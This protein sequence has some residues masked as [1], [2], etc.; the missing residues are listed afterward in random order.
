VALLAVVEE[1]VVVLLATVAFPVLL[2]TTVTL[3]TTTVELAELLLSMVEFTVLVA[4]EVEL[5]VVFADAETVEFPELEAVAAAVKL[6][7]LE[8]VS[9]AVVVDVVAMVE[10]AEAAS[11]S[12]YL[13]S[14]KSLL[15]PELVL[16]EAVA[17]APANNGRSTPVMINFLVASSYVAP[18]ISPTGLT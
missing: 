7:V 16:L 5:L 1:L 10:D 12:S 13:K 8:V 4:E 18:V 6:T 11:P 15:P 3:L 17:L 9:A 14:F 2:A